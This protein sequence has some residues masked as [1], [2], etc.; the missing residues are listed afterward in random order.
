[1]EHHP[2]R[3]LR[4]IAVFRFLKAL[5]LVAAA[6]G[7][8]RLFDPQSQDQLDDWLQSL[9]YVVERPQIQGQISRITHPS[10]KQVRVALA[11]SAAYVMLFLTEGVGLWIG[12]VWAEYLTIGATSSFIPIEVFEI[13]RHTTALRIS[14]LIANAAIVAYLIYHRARARAASRRLQAAMA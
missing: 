13:S 10:V 9:P 2:A 11:G 14:V 1:M 7:L 5:L 8:L 6:I 3:A 12:Y 4:L